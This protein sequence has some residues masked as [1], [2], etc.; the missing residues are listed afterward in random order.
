MTGSREVGIRTWGGY[1]ILHLAYVAYALGASE[2][3]LPS[4]Q[5]ALDLAQETGDRGLT[6]DAMSHLGHYLEAFGQGEAAV[7]TYEGSMTLRREMGLVNASVEPQA[8]LARVCLAGGK[9]APALGYVE[10]ILSH[11][12]S[13]TLE[14][15]EQPLLVYLTCYRVLRAAADPRAEVVLEEGYRLLQEIAG[16][17]T[18]PELRSSFLENVAAHRE[19][20]A[21]YARLDRSVRP[22]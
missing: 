19:V 21:E 2:Q 7:A 9:L 13:G 20:V 18:D 16:K 4:V 12:E 1:A 15:T 6:A 8:G 14:G 10:E 22:G 17:I 5:Q 11:L 3:A